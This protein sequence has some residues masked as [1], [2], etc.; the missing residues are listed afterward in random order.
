MFS[1]H[2]VERSKRFHYLDGIRSQRQLD[3]LTISKCTRVAE[4]HMDLIWY[5]GTVHSEADPERGEGGSSPGLIL[6]P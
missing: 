5:L 2:Y 4:S 6:N 1:C 3:N